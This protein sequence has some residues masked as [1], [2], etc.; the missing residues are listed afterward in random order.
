VRSR[1]T[2]DF[3]EAFAR[4]PKQIQRQA[5]KAYQV[6]LTN[7]ESPGLH[8]KK[9]HALRQVD[10]IRISRNYRALGVLENAEITR[11]WIGSHAEYDQILKGSER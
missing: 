4:L 5:R 7:P 9:I 1:I 11:F 6:F 3:R 2:E 8:F 10:S